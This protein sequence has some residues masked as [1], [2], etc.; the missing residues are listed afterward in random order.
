MK[1]QKTVTFTMWLEPFQNLLNSEVKKFGTLIGNN[2]DYYEIVDQLHDLPTKFGKGKSK[3]AR[4]AIFTAIN[5][6]C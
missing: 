5:G 4:K 2:K 3:L 6:I 1:N